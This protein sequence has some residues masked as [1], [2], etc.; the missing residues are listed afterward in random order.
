MS[1]T[2]IHEVFA[3]R[4]HGLMHLLRFYIRE[5]QGFTVGERLTV[6][7]LPGPAGEGPTLRFWRSVWVDAWGA[8]RHA[9]IEFGNIQATDPAHILFGPETL[10]KSEAIG[11][12]E[13]TVRNGGYKPIHIDL[14]D[15]FST[16]EGEE[17]TTE[18][19][20]GGSTKVSLESEQDVEGFAKFKEAVELEAH[21][22]FSESQ[23]RSKSTSRGTEGEEDTDV[24][25]G[26]CIVATESRARADTVQEVTASGAFT[27]TIVAGRFAPHVKSNHK[28]WTVTWKSWQAFLDVVN[29]RA[30]DNQPMAAAFKANPIQHADRWALAD[31]NAPLRYQA[32]YEGKIIR[33]YEVRKCSAAEEATA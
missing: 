32:S 16:D 8:T 1:A 12:T 21:A 5:F 33:S 9:F 3:H 23:S 4:A 10:T 7:L 13:Q 19:S 30:A 15:L 25:V 2:P 29:G 17:D 14:K 31:I 24:P 11:S 22:E 27:H 6:D 26:G 28:W 18:K 20:A